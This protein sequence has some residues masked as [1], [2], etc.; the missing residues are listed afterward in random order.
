[1]GGVFPEQSHTIVLGRQGAKISLQRKLVPDQEISIRCHATGRESDAR[2]VGQIGTS[3]EG[4]NIFAAAR[5]T[6]AKEFPSSGESVYGV[7]YVPA[8]QAW[9]G[10]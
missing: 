5:I 8:N 10:R 4:A 9:T 7:A 1:M 2:V 6:Y 3:P